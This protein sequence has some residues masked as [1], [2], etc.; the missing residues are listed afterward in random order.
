MIVVMI[1]TFLC[2]NYYL[3]Y[4]SHILFVFFVLLRLK[5]SL[6]VLINNHKIV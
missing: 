2:F 5:K 4:I 3:I 6:I 1:D